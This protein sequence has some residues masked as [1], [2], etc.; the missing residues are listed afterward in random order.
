MTR[1][2]LGAGVQTCALPIWGAAEEIEGAF[3]FDHLVAPLRERPH[4]AVAPAGQR[5]DVDGQLLE[6]GYRALHERAG[7]GPAE[8]ALAGEVG[9]AQGMALRRRHERRGGEVAEALARREQH[10]AVARSE[11][12]PSELQ[13]LMRL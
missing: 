8:R 11:E 4:H 12:Q 10:L 6:V 2:A 1:C 13:S 7:E 3:G 5:G 9:R